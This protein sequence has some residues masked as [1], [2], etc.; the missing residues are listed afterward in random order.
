MKRLWET[1]L[2]RS[3][4]AAEAEAAP[5]TL[6]GT[7]AESFSTPVMAHG[8]LS[9]P[10]VADQAA[11]IFQEKANNQIP[12]LLGCMTRL[13]W[14]SADFH[15][16]FMH[17]FENH[18]IAA[19]RLL[20]M[21]NNPFFVRG[22]RSTTNSLGQAIAWLGMSTVVE[23]AL[24]GATRAI[25]PA[26]AGRPP[27]D[28]ASIFNHS[29]AVAVATRRIAVTVCN[30]PATDKTAFTIGL[31]HDVGLAA[32]GSVPVAQPALFD[33]ANVQIMSGTRLA[34][35][36]FVR[37]G[38]SHSDCGAELA[39]IWAIP[40]II[41]TVIA[42]HHHPLVD[43]TDDEMTYIHCLKAAE[44]ICFSMGIGYTDIGHLAKDEYAQSWSWLGLDHGHMAPHLME[45]I[46]GEIRQME[47]IGWFTAYSAAAVQ[48]GRET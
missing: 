8:T 32:I 39:G 25:F 3:E 21:G 5:P 34:D 15:R 9:A 40:R 1:L 48:Q 16:E 45:S 33:A 2:G 46:T 4:P 19:A 36:E 35:E 13:S 44:W 41:Q 43:G 10:E 7:A 30:K 26:F 47:R 11:L 12:H 38:F 23:A 37:L 20:R 42:R 17:F 28:Y 29:L 14:Q 27:F 24:T 31:L 22:L 18:G 6:S